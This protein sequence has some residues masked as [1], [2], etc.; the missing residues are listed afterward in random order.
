MSKKTIVGDDGKEYTVKEK[1]P[2]YKKWWFILIVAIIVI[3]IL[4]KAFGG[5]TNTS[6]TNSSSTNQASDAAPEAQAEEVSYTKVDASQLLSDLESNALKAEKTYK[7]QNLEILGKVFNIDSSGEYINI[8][9]TNDEFTITGISCQLQNDAQRDVVAEI[10]KGSNVIVKGK[11]TAVGEVM[12]YT[13]T[14]DEI[15]PQ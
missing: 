13:V 1:K 5:D 9:G 12:G 14:V 2:F 8:D 7:D 15:I 3:S 4:G 6:S 11:V 10:T